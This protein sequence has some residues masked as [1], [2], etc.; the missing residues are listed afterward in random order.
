MSATSSMCHGCGEEE[1]HASSGVI[2]YVCGTT[3]SQF[4]TSRSTTCHGIEAAALRKRITELV[5]HVAM[6]EE[7]GNACAETS[8]TPQQMEWERVKGM[9]P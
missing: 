8:T 9:K 2:V 6:L 1:M 5:E 4:G 3:L 7:A